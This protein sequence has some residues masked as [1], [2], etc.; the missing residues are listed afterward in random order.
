MSDQNEAIE[1]DDLT[2]EDEVQ[3]TMLATGL[4]YSLAVQAVAIRRGEVTGCLHDEE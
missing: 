4:T 1:V 2:F 3:A